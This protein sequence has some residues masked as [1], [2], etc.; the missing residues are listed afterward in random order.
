MLQESSSYLTFSS[1][2]M[3]T[4]DLDAIYR[5][6]EMSEG[7]LTNEQDG[8]FANCVRSPLA[9]PHPHG[10]PSPSEPE[11][12]LLS[13]ADILHPFP[14]RPP[15]SQFMSLPDE[16]RDKIYELLGSD[17]SPC[18]TV[19]FRSRRNSESIS[20]VH[21]SEQGVVLGVSEGPSLDLL[22]VSHEFSEKYAARIRTR[23]T[24]TFSDT[25]HRI[26]TSVELNA[27]Q[28]PSQIQAAHFQLLSGC[29]FCGELEIHGPRAAT[30]ARR[31]WMADCEIE[32]EIG[33]HMAWIT[34]ALRDSFTYVKR[35]TIE[36]IL[37]DLDPTCGWPLQTGNSNL[38]VALELMVE[39]NPREDC[40]LRELTVA[41]AH[42]KEQ[43]HARKVHGVSDLTPPIPVGKWTKEHAW[44]AVERSEVVLQEEER[45]DEERR[46]PSSSSSAAAEEAEDTIAMTEEEEEE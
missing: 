23:A 29:A 30:V 35:Y 18:P 19:E 43:S 2:I 11:H 9:A 25:Y 34:T 22:L 41:L 16:L 45:E 46:I 42:R 3:A 37:Y 33:E 7:N 38:M 1:S 21:P 6:L 8:A 44:Q 27:T 4:Y 15:P 24:W 5:F 26:P 40:E 39:K 28:Y 13:D 12:V 10:R 20:L 32:Q 31:P 17:H 14:P 36:F